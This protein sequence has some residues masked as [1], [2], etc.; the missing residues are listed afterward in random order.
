MFDFRKRESI[1]QILFLFLFPN[2]ERMS[3]KNFKF[4]KILNISTRFLSRQ[5]C[6]IRPFFADPSPIIHLLRTLIVVSFSFSETEISFVIYLEIWASLNKNL[7]KITVSK[8][9]ILLVTGRALKNADSKYDQV[10]FEQIFSSPGVS[11]KR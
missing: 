6:L 2:R 4:L 7:V 8:L 10:L 3:L 5:F 1:C 9:S 11:I